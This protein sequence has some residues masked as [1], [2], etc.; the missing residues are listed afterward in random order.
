M[1]RRSAGM[2]QS[3]RVGETADYM[4]SIVTRTAPA[5]AVASVVPTS[6]EPVRR[7]KGK[8]SRASRLPPPVVPAPGPMPAAVSARSLD[9]CAAAYGVGTVYAAA[10]I[11]AM[12]GAADD[13]TFAVLGGAGSD[14]GGPSDSDS[15]SVESDGPGGAFPHA[16]AVTAFFGPSTGRTPRK[17]HALASGLEPEA[18]WAALAAGRSLASAAEPPAA[19]RPSLSP[20]ALLHGAPSAPFPRSSAPTGSGSALLAEARRSLEA[21]GAEGPSARGRAASL[22][23][24]P[25]SGASPGAGGGGRVTAPRGMPATVA[26]W[27][28]AT[29]RGMGRGDGARG[30][31]LPPGYGWM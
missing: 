31:Q 9:R 19:K 5:E 3:A 11:V 17:R 18:V 1:P 20:S 15:E 25:L 6:A 23:A 10:D 12:G 27:S 28:A 2:S 13:A 26:R 7:K 8:R 22:S 4:M 24:A 30:R 29:G 21:F 14:G 16:E